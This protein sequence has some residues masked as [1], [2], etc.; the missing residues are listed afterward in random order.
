MN[1]DC[2]FGLG[3][4]D[5]TFLCY[6]VMFISQFDMCDED[7]E[8]YDGKCVDSVAWREDRRR[9]IKLESYK[10]EADKFQKE[11]EEFMRKLEE[12]MKHEEKT[13]V[14]K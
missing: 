10:R 7:A 6:C 2:S 9:S 3:S 11:H 14:C 4:P 12:R 13:G 1:N 8:Y 5:V